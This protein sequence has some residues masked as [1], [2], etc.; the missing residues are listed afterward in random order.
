MCRA[1]ASGN[2]LIHRIE[3]RM[4][5]RQLIS[6]SNSLTVRMDDGQGKLQAGTFPCSAKEHISIA[7][8]ADEAGVPLA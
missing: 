3:G 7:S 6:F 1:R 4:P 2:V 8:A 5:P